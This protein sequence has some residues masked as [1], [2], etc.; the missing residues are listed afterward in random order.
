[1][2]YTLELFEDCSGFTLET[3]EVLC[4]TL[5]VDGEQIGELD[6]YDNIIKKLDTI[7]DIEEK[8]TLTKEK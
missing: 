6:S 2:K 7:M 1:M 5:F 3:P 4:W 8:F